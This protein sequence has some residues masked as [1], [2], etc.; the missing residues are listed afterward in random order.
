L[1]RNDTGVGQITG[2]IDD[3]EFW[4]ATQTTIPTFEDR[5]TT[6]NFTNIAGTKVGVNT[7]TQVMDW[8]SSVN[9]VYN[10]G[11]FNDLIG[12]PISTDSWILRCKLVINT[13]TVGGDTTSNDLFIGFSDDNTSLPNVAQDFVG[14]RWGL[15]NPDGA[16]RTL[17]ADDQTI[18]ASPGG[19]GTIYSTPITTGT[20]YLETIRNGSNVTGTIYSDASFTQVIETVTQSIEVGITG[21]RYLKV[22]VGNRDGTGDHTFDGT[23]DNVE[24]Y[25]GITSIPE[26][27]QGEQQV[28]TTFQDDFTTDQWTDAGT[29]ISVNTGTEVIDWDGLR[30]G[31][32]RATAFDLGAGNVSD[33]EWIL[34]WKQTNDNVTDTNSGSNGMWFGIS[35]EDETSDSANLQDYLMIGIIFGDFKQYQ[36]QAGDG[37]GLASGQTFASAFTA[38]V[39]TETVY[40]EIKRT[41]STTFE[42]TQYSDANYSVVI[43]KQIG[44]I[45]STI[46]NLRYIKCVGF[47]QAGDGGTLDGTI[48]DVQFWD[49]ISVFPKALEVQQ[50][51]QTFE[52][53]FLQKTATFTDDFNTNDWT[54]SNTARL[55]IDNTVDEEADFNANNVST[56]DNSTMF[57][58]LGST[59]TNDENW[60]LRFKLDV[61]T[62]TQNAD[63]T[64]QTL[65]I[66]L[67]DSTADATVNQDWIGLTLLIDNLSII[68]RARAVDGA[69]I[70]GGGTDFTRVLQVET[71]YIEIKRTSATSCVVRQFSDA[72]YTTLLEEQTVAIPSTLSSL[73]YLKMVTQNSDGTAD[74]VITGH[75]DDLEFY[76][77]VST[78]T[79]WTTTGT[80]VLIDTGNKRIEASDSSDGTYNAIR[81]DLTSFPV[82]DTNWTLRFK[83]D[84]DNLVARTS[85]QAILY[86]GLYDNIGD[87]DQTQDAIVLMFVVGTGTPDVVI[88]VANNTDLQTGTS[89]FN[90]TDA[91]VAGQTRFYELKRTSATTVEA[92]AYSDASYRNLIE[93]VSGTISAGIVGTNFLAVKTANRVDATAVIEA[94][95]D[96]LEFYNGVSVA[97]TP[98]FE[99][100]DFEDNFFED[101]W[102]DQGT[103]VEVNTGTQVID[104]TSILDTVVRATVFDLGAGNVN[105]TEWALRFKYRIDTLTAGSTR[106][107]FFWIGLFDSDETVDSES[108]QDF[109][110]FMFFV[111]STTPVGKF[112]LSERNNVILESAGTDTELTTTPSAQLGN[113]LY[114]EIKRLSATLAE[115]SLYSDPDY[116]ILIERISLTVPAGIID[117]RYIGL[118]NRTDPVNTGSMT[119]IIDDVQ[120][121]D[122]QSALDHENTWRRV[123]L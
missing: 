94:F 21:L 89:D 3:I 116:S 23:I 102:A 24:F 40:W 48:D 45:P 50:G 4:G 57:F 32:N 53:N 6:D 87:D 59:L 81:T 37:A 31:V 110:G 95:I 30:T 46:V 7:G 106:T 67:S 17:T 115:F 43:E 49:G 63:I 84:I 75:V 112:F 117:L 108:V 47:N 88:R 80:S 92:S 113:N 83:I 16:I 78:I 15:N 12:E 101:N 14:W 66:G 5:F 56:T 96:D 20:F 11:E 34:R 104:W 68:Y 90:F 79:D 18:N 85:T 10:E 91:P 61:T 71:I 54:S 107:K 38:T 82:S 58:D 100:K 35:D 19:A 105:D 72:Q 51:D 114:V 109:I 64:P 13:V 99:T 36:L 120:F 70:A 69:I 28:D 118:K 97:K 9:A 60:A 62:V 39:T 65:F 27:G 8:S 55:D 33:T 119:G 25:D 42:A 26:I 86:A 29:G 41:S 73:R 44:V 93:T 1:N 111:N 122:K 103:G 52:D 123:D 74:H 2:V 22:L 98:I 77:G 76:N 121:W